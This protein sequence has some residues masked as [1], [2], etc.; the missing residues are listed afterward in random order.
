MDNRDEIPKVAFSQ[1]LETE[2]LDSLDL[3]DP[4]YP[5]EVSDSLLQAS[6]FP[7]T[8][9][10]LRSQPTINRRVKTI[11]LSSNGNF[12]IKQ[13]VPDAILENAQYSKGEEF[14]TMR[15]S[16]VTCDPNDFISQG[17]DIRPAK[18]LRPIEIFVIVTMYNEDHVYCRIL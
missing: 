9:T 1:D 12:V 16:A 7:A 18:Y 4:F 6:S 2:A 14:Q 17:Y 10:L 3:K 8:N 11:K 15:Y 5:P 13:R